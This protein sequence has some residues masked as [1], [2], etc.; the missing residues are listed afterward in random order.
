MMQG[1]QLFYMKI[2]FIL[3]DQRTIFRFNKPVLRFQEKT[4]ATV[5]KSLSILVKIPAISFCEIS[6]YR[7][8]SSNELNIYSF[9][10]YPNI[11]ISRYPNISI[12]QYLNIPISQYLISNIKIQ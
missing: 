11:S 3:N 7:I 10:Q 6:R 9:L 2:V 1:L 4:S 12:S 5:A 8:I